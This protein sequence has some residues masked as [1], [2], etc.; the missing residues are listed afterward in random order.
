MLDLTWQLCDLYL[1]NILDMIFSLQKCRCWLSCCAKLVA[2][3]DATLWSWYNYS[4]SICMIAYLFIFITYFTDILL[5]MSKRNLYMYWHNCF[6][7]STYFIWSYRKCYRL[8]YFDCKL[9]RIFRLF[10]KSYIK[11]NNKHIHNMFRIRKFTSEP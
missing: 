9:F 2:G 10:W 7:L 11:L 6:S 4:R 8:K 3:Q 5:Q 1:I